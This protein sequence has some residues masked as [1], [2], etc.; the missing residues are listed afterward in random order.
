[1]NVLEPIRGN[2]EIKPVFYTTCDIEVHN[3]INFLCIGFYDGHDKV[4]KWFD[5][6]SDFLDFIFEYQAMNLIPNCFAHF[7]GKFD[8]NFIIEAIMESDKYKIV[9]DSLIERGSGLLCFTMAEVEPLHFNTNGKPFEL[10]FR[11]SSALLP[12]ALGSLTKAFGV[13]TQKGEMC[14]TF[15]DSIWASKDY[16]KEVFAHEKMVVLYKGKAVSS[17]RKT[18]KKEFVEYYNID[19]KKKVYRIFDREDMLDYLQADCIALWQVI[20]VFYS[21]ELVKKAGLCFTTASQAV[22]IWQTFL[23]KKVYKLSKDVDRFVREGYFG[24]RTEVFKPIFDATYDVKSNKFNFSKEQLKF[25]Q[26]QKKIGEIYYYD[27]NSLYPTVM[28]DHEYPVKCKGWAYERH[29]DPNGM[30]MWKCTVEVP[31]EMFC[32]PL[33]VKHIVNGTEKLIFPTGTFTGI[34]TTAEIEYAKSIG[35]KVKKIFKGLV[36]ESGGYIFKDFIVTLYNMRL[37]AK[38]NKDSV[39]D[40][41]TKL[42][43]NSC[44]GRLGLN[45][46]RENLMLDNGESGLRHH[47]TVQ[48]KDKEIRFMKKETELNNAFSNVAISAYVTAYAR[49]LM[50]KECYVKAGKEHL[51]YTDTDSIFSTKKF[52]TGDALGELKLEY[53]CKSSVFLLPKTYI[54]EGITGEEFRKKLTMKGFDKKKIKHFTIEDFIN[55]MR[56]DAKALRIVQDAKFASLKSALNKGKFVT[57]MYDEECDRESDRLKMQELEKRVKN[58]ELDK[59]EVSRLKSRIKRLKNKEYGKSYRAI[60]SQ[61]DKRIMKHGGFE[62]D[63]IHIE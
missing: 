48:F 37:E 36:F 4:Y 10:V 30:G 44:Y 3:W 33:G 51:Y 17:Y 27:I 18:M 57:R 24:G 7:G 15:T 28:R 26:K 62:T 39:N 34:W 11:D 45:T 1:M 54:N 29:Y 38:R 2:R 63:P 43:M 50:H 35:V 42:I 32:P 56:G 21:W 41:L 58:P 61:Y 13:E 25:I 20:E 47:T 14:F 59:K 60:K 40:M 52:K 49:L 12:N 16:T 6:M 22:K 55:S 53:K 19:D 8:F 23:D 46:E 9:E 31:K 5:K